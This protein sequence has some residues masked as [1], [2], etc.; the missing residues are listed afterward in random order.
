[1][2]KN[3]ITG[4]IVFIF[5][6]NVSIVSASMF[7]DIDE[8]HPYFSTVQS[9]YNMGVVNGYPDGSFKPDNLINRAEFLKIV[10]ERLNYEVSGGNCFSDVKDQWFAP[11]VCKAY[12]EGIVNGYPDGSFKPE[13]NIN[14]VEASKIVNTAMHISFDEDSGEE[15]WYMLYVES[16]AESDAIPYTVT[17]FDHLMKRGEVSYLLVVFK[18]SYFSFNTLSSHLTYDDLVQM[19]GLS[20]KAVFAYKFEKMYGHELDVDGVPEG[21]DYNSFKRILLGTSSCG[22]GV[23]GCRLVGS[24]LYSDDYRVYNYPPDDYDSELIV[25]E[26]VDS[27]S[28]EI[29]PDILNKCAFDGVNY[30]LTDKENPIYHPVDYVPLFVQNELEKQKYEIVYSFEFGSFVIDENGFYY[31]LEDYGNPRELEEFDAGNFQLILDSYPVVLFTDGK[32]IWMAKLMMSYGFTE[33]DVLIER[34]D[35]VNFES[36][37]LLTLSSHYVATPYFKDE[38]KVYYFGESRGEPLSS[39]A[40]YLVSDEFLLE[41]SGVDVDSFEVVES[42]GGYSYEDFFFEDKDKIYFGLNGEMLEVSG[43]DKNS[44]EIV[45]VYPVYEVLNPAYPR[46]YLR[47]EN[48]VWIVDFDK[49]IEKLEGVLPGEFNY[50]EYLGDMG[51]EHWSELGG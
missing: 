16:I 14:F 44:F 12:E 15:P 42:S 19:E 3:L 5:G 49:N 30:Y 18:N 20:E 50:E 17:G 29:F 21:V 31:V 1:M 46:Y 26:G 33:E 6:L 11:Y 47:D 38:D 48:S 51:V 37:E 25:L 34:L 22:F 10:M 36:F 28:F 40:Y 4:L 32:S 9:L 27:N 35:F 13:I 24:E 45:F 43:V 41:V 8:S 39:N 23:D 7:S 2:K